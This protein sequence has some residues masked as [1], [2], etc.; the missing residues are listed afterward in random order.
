MREVRVELGERSYPVYVGGGLLG[1]L[2]PLVGSTAGDKA[3]VVITDSIVD[4]HYGERVEASLQRIYGSIHRL[5]VESGERSKSLDIAASL[6]E[7]MAER[8]I[9]R[10]DVLLALGGGMVSDLAG[11]VASVYQRGIELVNLPTTLLGQVD[12]AVGG[13]TAV[14]L[15]S[16]KNL[17]GTFYQPSAVVCDVEALRTLPP[18]EF[19]SGMAEVVKYGLCFEF[20]LLDLLESEDVSPASDAGQLERIVASCVAHKARVVSE[21]EGDEGARLVLNYGHTFGHA[22]EAHGGFE[23]FTHGE[24]ISV[25]M[26]FAAILS[27]EAG[28]LEES[29]V[30]RHE[31]VLSAVGLPTTAP[32]DPG[33]IVRFW[34]LDKKYRQGQRWVLLKAI[35]EPVVVSDVDG[36]AVTR[37]LERVRAA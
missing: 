8:R 37:A 16:G 24:A 2:A 13:K 31:K 32:F 14:N 19:R 30:V 23:R 26:M 1:E 3:A 35:G 18:R 9:R 21:D 34:S 22:L 12:A 15:L 28:F 36:A 7:Q 25:G 20:E 29:A 17:A 10:R 11:F 5:V 27:N 33:E 4:S 6:L